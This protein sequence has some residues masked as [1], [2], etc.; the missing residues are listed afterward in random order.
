MRNLRI[1]TV[2]IDMDETLAQ[3]PPNYIRFVHQPTGGERLPRRPPTSGTATTTM[4]WAREPLGY[5]WSSSAGKAATRMW[6]A[7]R[8]PDLREG[9]IP[10]QHG[11]L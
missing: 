11:H 7:P 9:A 8:P 3:L 4:W 10:I 1:K 6:T 2:F 5:I